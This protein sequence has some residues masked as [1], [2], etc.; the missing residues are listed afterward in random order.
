[1]NIPN[2]VA[3][4]KNKI[5]TKEE[6]VKKFYSRNKPWIAERI[7]NEVRYYRGLATKMEE[8]YERRKET[9]NQDKQN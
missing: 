8:E 4:L 6:Q 9:G 3:A 2:E 1:M 5:R 7:E